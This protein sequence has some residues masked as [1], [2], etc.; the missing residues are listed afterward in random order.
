[1]DIIKELEQKMTSLVEFLRQELMGVRSNR[2]SPRLVEDIPVEVYGQ[3]MT[4]R[5]VGAISIQP[6]SSILIS[7]WDKDVVNTVAK[8][9]ESSNLNV[10]ANT[11]GTTIRINLPALTDE[12]RQQIIK[13]VKKEV[14]EAKIKV[15][16]LRD[17]ENKRVAREAEEGNLTE[18]EKFKLKEQIQ[19]VV[20]RGNKELDQ[21]LEKKIVE[22]NE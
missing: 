19:E 20:D 10:V 7:V 12:R 1:M 15:R 6:P 13:M 17:D 16:S 3:R 11:D 18:D 21:L 9:I 14:E 2:P 8:A 5:Q 22:I 4:V